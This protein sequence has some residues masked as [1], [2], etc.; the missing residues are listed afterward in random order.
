MGWYQARLLLNYDNSQHVLQILKMS[1]RS[2]EEAISD[3]YNN[4]CTMMYTGICT[5]A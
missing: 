2:L 1:D 3:C 5:T 4:A